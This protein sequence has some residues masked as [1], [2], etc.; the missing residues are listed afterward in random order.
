MTCDE[1]EAKHIELT[2]SERDDLEYDQDSLATYKVQ[3]LREAILGNYH[4]R[5]L[6]F[7]QRRLVNFQGF[8]RHISVAS[9]AQFDFAFK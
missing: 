9:R 6:V 8:H 2:V 7:I 3:G 1:Y 4:T 5:P